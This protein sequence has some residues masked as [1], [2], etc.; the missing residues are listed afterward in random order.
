[1]QLPVVVNTVK[2]TVHRK[3]LTEMGQRQ[4]L[5]EDPKWE[6]NLATLRG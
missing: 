1:M 2:T 3:H 5:N 6:K 4:H